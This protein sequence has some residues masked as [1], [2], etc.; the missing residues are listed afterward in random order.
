MIEENRKKN[1]ALP[2]AQAIRSNIAKHDAFEK[3]I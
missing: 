3:R 1:P 2:A